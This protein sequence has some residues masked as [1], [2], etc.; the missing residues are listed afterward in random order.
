MKPAILFASFP[1]ILLLAQCDK[2][3]N[4]SPLEFQ[5]GKSFEM[6]YQDTGACSCGDLSITFRDVVEDSRCP[7]GAVCVWEGQARVQL[8]VQ[9][10]DGSQSIELAFQA[11]RSSFD[12]DTVGGYAISLMN[13]SPHPREGQTIKKQDYRIRL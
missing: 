6:S 9:S 8:D 5:P 2:K 13:V 11:S 7:T 12:R 10:E 3:N 1:L 4:H